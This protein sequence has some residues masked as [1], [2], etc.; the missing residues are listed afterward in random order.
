MATC[1][2]TLHNKF[3]VPLYLSEWIVEK[4]AVFALKLLGPN[5][6]HV[7]FMHN[8]RDRQIKI[9]YT[10]AIVVRRKS[11]SLEQTRNNELPRGK[12]LYNFM[13]L[14]WLE[15]GGRMREAQLHRKFEKA[16]IGHPSGRKSEYFRMTEDLSSF[17]VSRNPKLALYSETGWI[18]KSQNPEQPPDEAL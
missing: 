10:G 17:L 1:V 4:D 3:G 7:Y 9:G 13:R 2:D 6:S 18:V 16:R 12:K 8:I 14:L 5:P 15:P 11:L